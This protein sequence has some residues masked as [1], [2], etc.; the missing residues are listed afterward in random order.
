MKLSPHFD[1]SEA[2]CHCGCLMPPDI[3][4]NVQA[5]VYIAESVR[6][7]LDLPMI[8]DSWYRCPTYNA[9]IGGAPNSMHVYGLAIDFKAPPLTPHQV[10]D[11]CVEVQNRGLV[12][13]VEYADAHTHIDAREARIFYGS[14]H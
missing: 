6:A 8:I 10:S 1:W 5:M 13:G 14:S 4:R 11:V 3:A 7:V 12:G 2:Q 9:A